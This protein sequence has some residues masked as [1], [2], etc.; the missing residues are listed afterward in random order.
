M[1]SKTQYFQN[2]LGVFQGGGCRG[3]AFAGAFK[4]ATNRGV[5]FSEIVGT[6]AGSIVAV[7]IAAGATPLQLEEIVSRLDFM[8]LLRNPIKLSNYSYH[9]S[10]NLIYPFRKDIYDVWTK[11]GRYDS[12]GIETW[13]DQELRKLLNLAGPVKFE[14]L[15]IPT[16]IVVSDLKDRE[17]QLFGN[18]YD[19]NYEVA[20]AVRKSCN[21]PIFFQPIDKRYVD[22]GGC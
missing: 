19:E 18:A 7:L 10:A 14:N 16:T 6:S 13:V 5:S 15:I 8:S 17:V 22:G 12:G 2:C 3:A 1:N 21:I 11:L 9:W 20:A 4:E